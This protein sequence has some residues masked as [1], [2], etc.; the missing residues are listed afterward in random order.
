MKLNLLITTPPSPIALVCQY[1]NQLL[2]GGSNSVGTITLT[3]GG[4][5]TTLTSNL[6]TS[7]S[8]IVLTPQTAHASTVTGIWYDPT[9]FV[10]QV[11]GV[12]GSITINHSSVSQSDLTFGYE[13]RN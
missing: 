5:T 13:I 9:S 3:N 11:G 7:Q 6:L 2:N 10:F 8:L 1:V 12:G 4:T